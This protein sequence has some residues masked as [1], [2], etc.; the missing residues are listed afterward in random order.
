MIQRTAAKKEKMLVLSERSE[1]LFLPAA[2]RP[3]SP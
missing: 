3:M 2:Q 1:D